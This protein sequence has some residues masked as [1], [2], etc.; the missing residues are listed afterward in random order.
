MNNFLS[1]IILISFCTQGQGQGNYLG[2]DPPGLVPELFAPNLVSLP[3]Q[4][5]FGSVFSDDGNEFFYAVDEKG[6]AKILRTKFTNGEW[7]KAQI[8]ISHESYSYNDPMLSPDGKKLYFISD[9][10]LDGQGNN[11]DYDIWYAQRLKNSWSS[12]INIESP[13]NTPK[14]EYYISFS[15]DGTLYFSSNRAAVKGQGNDFDIYKSKLVK[16]E[17][18]SPIKMGLPINSERYEADV[19][20][21][22]QEDYMIFCT[23]RQDGLGRGDL[24]ISFKNEE[25]NWTT[26]VN[27][28][29]EI[30][31]EL[32]QLCPFVS[33]DGKYLFFT[34]N[35][36]IFWVDAKIIGNYRK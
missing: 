27:M 4:H 36:D 34:S 18:T 31:S 8:M 16:G 15:N 20:I 19:Y 9:Q 26:A 10:P 13:I 11:K 17:Y 7:E 29:S 21:S 30:N 28:G 33:A 35:G 22:P 12:P 1:L 24:Y 6:K 32:H 23:N 25:D 5:E 2:Q 3:D 14:N